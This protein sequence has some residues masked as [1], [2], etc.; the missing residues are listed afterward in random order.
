MTLLNWQIKPRKDEN[1]EKYRNIYKLKRWFKS[2]YTTFIRPVLERIAPVWHSS[3]S[4]RN[5]YHLEKIQ[6]PV[7]HLIIDIVQWPC[8]LWNVFTITWVARTNRQMFQRLSNCGTHSMKNRFKVANFSFEVQKSSSLF[9]L[10]PNGPGVTW[11]SCIDL[12]ERFMGSLGCARAF[13]QT[14]LGLL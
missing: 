10:V 7:V 11:V 1:L 6:E 8:E 12:R 13:L 4:A 5:F 2:I 9:C 14:F 3:P